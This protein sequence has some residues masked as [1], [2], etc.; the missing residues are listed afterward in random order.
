M[1]KPGVILITTLMIVMVMS[2]ISMQI[3]KNFFIALKREAYLD[4]KNLSYQMLLSSEAQAIETVKREIDSYRNKLTA[5][6]PLLTKN[7]TYDY[8]IFSL[9]L[10]IIDGS[11]CFN[12]NSI[13]NISGKG[14]E[15]NEP[16]REWLNRYLQLK[17]LNPT[18]IESFFDQLID[19]VDLDNQPLNFGAENYYYMGPMSQVNQFTPKRLLVDLS[20]IKNLPVMRNLN[21]LDI[22]THL[23]VIPGSTSQLININTLKPTDTMLIASFFNEKN[24][25]YVES[26]ITSL[27]QEGYDEVNSF[28]AKFKGAANFPAQILSTNSK[29]FKLRTRLIDESFS[30]ELESLVILDVSNSAKV[31][32]RNFNF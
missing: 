20:E 8:D 5:N 19:W 29:T 1:N 16:R 14:Y 24:L 9:E 15:V 12:L 30:A 18:D 6:N 32:N 4:F 26:Q 11:N 27:P 31:L 10:K 13:F 25:E 28:I 3:S 17:L 21:F 23:C 7:F 22:A 2:I